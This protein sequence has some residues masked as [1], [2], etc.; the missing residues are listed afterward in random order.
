LFNKAKHRLFVFLTRQEEEP[1]DAA[2]A[3]GTYQQV[4]DV[5]DD[6]IKEQRSVI[7]SEPRVLLDHY[8]KLLK[9]SFMENTEVAKLARKI[10]QKHSR[11]LDVILEF[12]PDALQSLTDAIAEKVKAESAALEFEEPENVTGHTTRPSLASQQ[13]LGIFPEDADTLFDAKFIK[14]TMACAA[15]SRSWLRNDLAAWAWPRSSARSR[16]SSSR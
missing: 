15:A 6:C 1:E 10:Y 13:T 3:S 5:L 7:G 2:W 12:R 8:L 11:A 9:E 4:H 16:A 14:S